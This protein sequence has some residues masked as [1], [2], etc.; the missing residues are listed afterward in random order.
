MRRTSGSTRPGRHETF[1]CPQS[2]ST[3][4]CQLGTEGCIEPFNPACCQAG[5][6]ECP[7]KVTPK[8]KPP[9]HHNIG[10]QKTFTCPDGSSYKCAPGSE[11][12]CIEPI[13]EACCLLG[14]GECPF[15]VDRRPPLPD[16]DICAP[17]PVTSCPAI[18]SSCSAA[19]ENPLCAEAA[20]FC[21]WLIQETDNEREGYVSNAVLRRGV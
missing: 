6:K 2:G 14:A 10:R 4:S 17:F 19:P 7:Y 13:N 8:K 1:T 21:N 16:L 11:Q 20:P 3:Y 18:L 12:G 15:D 5:A 9:H